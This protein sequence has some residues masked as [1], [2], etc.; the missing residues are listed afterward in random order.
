MHVC[1][2]MDEHTK[3][4]GGD[5]TEPGV[6]C[7]GFASQQWGYIIHIL[8]RP[9]NVKDSACSLAPGSRDQILT[10]D[11]VVYLSMPMVNYPFK[12]FP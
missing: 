9:N 10:W 1:V 5:Q 6:H 4:F 8:Y 7:V 2:C 11:L 12:G 3:A